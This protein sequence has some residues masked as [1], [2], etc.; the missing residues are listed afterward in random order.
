MNVKNLCVTVAFLLANQ[1]GTSFGETIPFKSE[2]WEFSGKEAEVS[3]YKGQNAL[4]LHDAEATLRDSEFA[5]GTIEFDLLTLGDKGFS[6]VHWHLQDNGYDYEEFY[7]RP[8]Q[9]GNLDA[10]QYTPSFNGLAA[11]QIYYG[12]HYSVSLDYKIDDWMHVKIVVSGNQAEV[13]IDSNDPILF[14]D[15]LK[16]DFGSGKLRLRSGFAPAYF[17]NF[18]YDAQERPALK[19]HALEPEAPVENGV[20]HF[21]VSTPVAEDLVATATVISVSQIP[22]DWVSLGVETNGIANIARARQASRATN[23]VFARVTINSDKVQTKRL[24]FGYSDRVRVFYEGR[25]IYS[26]NN[27]YMSR[28]YRYL[29]TVGLFDSVYLSLKTGDN[30]VY[31]AVSENFWG[32]AIMAGFD[33]MDGIS[34]R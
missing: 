25:A 18:S 30:D 27:G 33:D 15:D 8:H 28:D 19:G 34:V 13:Y 26:G 20:D 3:E 17:A 21:Y 7:I 22:N 2:Q 5:D 11:W 23:T 14:I 32:W 24:N 6:G 12:P 10:N 16:G 9:S 4:F 31:F 1:V 29:G